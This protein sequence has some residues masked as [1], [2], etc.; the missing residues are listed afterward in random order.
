MYSGHR[1]EFY[2]VRVK[3]GEQLATRFLRH[4]VSEDWDRASSFLVGCFPARY[5]HEHLMRV[6]RN[7]LEF[8]ALDEP[9]DLSI[10]KPQR[11]K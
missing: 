7:A 5:K 4:L 10:V 6:A 1:P 8:V 2:E 3:M 11:P 9:L